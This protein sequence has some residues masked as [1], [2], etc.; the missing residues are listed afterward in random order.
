MSLLVDKDGFSIIQLA[1]I[2]GCST[3]VLNTLMK[4]GCCITDEE[5]IIAAN[6]RQTHTLEFLLRHT[7]YQEGMIDLATCSLKVANALQKAVEKQ[8]MEEQ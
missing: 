8:N 2:F 7:A 1:V 3:S 5:V 6:T 4:A